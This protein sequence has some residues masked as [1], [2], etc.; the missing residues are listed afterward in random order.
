MRVAHAGVFVASRVARA[1]PGAARGGGRVVSKACRRCACRM[2]RVTSATEIAAGGFTPP[3]CARARGRARA[4]SHHGCAAAVLPCRGHEQADGRFGHQDRGVAPGIRLER[5]VSGGRATAGGRAPSRT[6]RWPQ[7][8]RAAMRA[9]APTAAIQRQA[10]RSPSAIPRSSSITRID[11]CTRW[12][13]T[14]KRSSTRTTA[15][16]RQPQSGTAARPEET[17]GS[18]L[19]RCT[20]RTSMASSPARRRIFDRACTP[21]AWCCIASSIDPPGSYIPAREVSGRSQ[22]GDG[23][24]RCERWRERR[25][26]RESSGMPIRSE[27]AAVQ[28]CGR[29]VVPHRR[30]GRDRSR[31]VLRHQASEDRSGPILS[32]AAAG[33][34]VVVGNARRT[35]AVFKCDGD[36]QISRGAGSGMGSG[37]VRRGGRRREDGR[38]SEGS[39]YRRGTT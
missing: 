2:R 39:Q 38:R 29:P 15:T 30:A 35:A 10:R 8:L 7:R 1:C 23:G 6:P 32:V 19:R 34:R 5:K 31:A 25:H 37:A 17:R 18:R 3:S 22:S 14:R 28:R 26:H 24:V 36:L 12:Q 27:S 4:R 33:I 9:Q 16:G 11:R 20:R 13:C 21:S